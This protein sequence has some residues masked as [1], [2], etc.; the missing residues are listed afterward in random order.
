MRRAL[1]WFSKHLPVT[2]AQ[3]DRH[4]A[5]GQTSMTVLVPSSGADPLAVRATMLSAA[6]QERPS[7]RVVLL[8]DDDP[9]PADSDDAARLAET[10][11]IAGD[12]MRLLAEPWRRASDALLRFELEHSGD[13]NADAS[14]ARALAG[15]YAWAAGWLR[16]LAEGE[17]SD[18][19]VGRLLADQVLRTL[20]DELAVI[21]EAAATAAVALSADRVN[22]L[23]SRLAWIFGAELTVFERRKYSST[24]HA[25]TTSS[26]VDAYRALMGGAHRIEETPDG[27]ALKPAAERRPGD[28]RV[29]GSDAVLT[30]DAGSL[31][32]RDSSRLLAYS[33]Q[34]PDA[35]RD[36]GA[37]ETAEA[38]T[39]ADVLAWRGMLYHCDAGDTLR[40]FAGSGDPTGK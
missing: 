33:L 26:N 11:A 7:V 32:L 38:A 34:G 28:I 31:L 27:T 35:A 1:Q 9:Y 25:P 5:S 8:L 40:D 17:E 20:A 29:P 30:L 23:Y 39:D 12:I 14:E 4:L 18:D 10:R 16:D 2:R 24:S 15:E 6:L 22:E 3:P 13:A 37:R 21:G 19:A 36:V